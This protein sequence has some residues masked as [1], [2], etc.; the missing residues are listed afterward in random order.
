MKP[1]LEND[2]VICA[3]NGIVQLK[4]DKGSD[5][6]INGN[7]AITKSDLINASISGCTHNIA[8]VPKPCTKIMQIPDNALSTLIETGGEKVVLEDMLSMIMTDNGVSLQLQGNQEK[9]LILDN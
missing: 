9:P 7:P 2:K 8:G 1:L 3:H 5:L 4:S 6:I